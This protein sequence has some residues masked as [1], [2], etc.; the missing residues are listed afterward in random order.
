MCVSVDLQ[1]GGLQ[2]RHCPM[3]MDCRWARELAAE[4]YECSRLAVV[5]S[6][7]WFVS[8]Q[9]IR[10]WSNVIEACLSNRQHPACVCRCYWHMQLAVLSLG[11]A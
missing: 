3:K 1:S 4:W 10:S 9:G 7:A 8:L 11:G 2:G 5:H 6:S